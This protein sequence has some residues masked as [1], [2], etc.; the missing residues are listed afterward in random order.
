MPGSNTIFFKL[1]YISPANVKKASQKERSAD[2]VKLARCIKLEVTLD[3]EQSDELT[4][5][6]NRIEEVNELVKIF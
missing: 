5:T 3:D 6:V 1:M 2:S 4:N